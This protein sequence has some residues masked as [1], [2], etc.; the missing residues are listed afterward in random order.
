MEPIRI[1]EG[2]NFAAEIPCGKEASLV[3][4]RKG[5]AQP[6]R[7]I[8]FAEE[9]RTGKICALL[10]RGLD[11]ERLEYN[12]RIDGTIVQDPYAYGIRGR[13]RFRSRPGL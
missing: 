7:E 8:P 13:E 10:V 6:W 2:L 3:L 4:Y 11:R 5:A 12:F 1:A 9:Y